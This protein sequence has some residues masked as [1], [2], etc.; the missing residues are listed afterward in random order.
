M[1]IKK[2]NKIGL[3]TMTQRFMPNGIGVG[4]GLQ[5]PV[6]HRPGTRPLT[7]RITVAEE[8]VLRLV[9]QAK[10]NKEIG[11]V[12]G[13]SPATVK[14]HIE[15]ILAKLGLRNRVEAALYGLTLNGCPHWSSAGCALRQPEIFGQRKLHTWAD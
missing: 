7:P 11:M 14:R 15:K 8:R 6:A 4:D 12:L 2:L 9:S 5:E 3:P 10:T 1:K 13:I